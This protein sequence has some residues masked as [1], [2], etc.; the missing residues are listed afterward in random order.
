[1]SADMMLEKW[2]DILRL[3]LQATERET[4]DLEQ[5]FENLKGHHA[6]ALP[7]P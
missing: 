7:Y 6:T 4:L 2:L 1:M 5:A 3:G